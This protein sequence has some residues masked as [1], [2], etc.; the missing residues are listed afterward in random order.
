MPNRK[1]KCKWCK[2]FYPREETIKL[3]SGR[4]CRGSTGRNC[5]TNFA[6]DDNNQAKAKKTIHKEKK[7]QVKPLRHWLD[8]TQKSFNR[9][10]VAQELYW[11]KSRGI[12]PECISCGGVNMDWC[13]GHYTSVG[14][15]SSL[16]FDEK[17]TYLQCNQYCNCQ[18]SG[19]KS[20]TKTTRGYDNGLA[21]RFGD[22]EAERIIDYC[23]SSK[24]IM[25]WTMED[26]EEK[27]KQYNKTYREIIKKLDNDS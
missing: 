11:Y 2:E 3:N 1:L 23:K 16:R 4:F 21:Y 25:K 18:L 24:E 26:L 13:C 5:I 9:M 14:S 20:G 17:N 8:L 6:L 10:R 7:K 19:N 15:D 12:E 27:R 22:E